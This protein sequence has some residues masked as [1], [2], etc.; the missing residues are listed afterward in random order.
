MSRERAERLGR[1]LDGVLT[2]NGPDDDP[3]EPADSWALALGAFAAS[4]RLEHAAAERLAR[5][6]VAALPADPDDDPLAAVLAYAMCG[7]AAAGT[8]SVGGWTDI[9]PGDTPTGDPLADAAALLPRLDRGCDADLFARYAVAEAALAAARVALADR[10]LGGP[11]A[12]RRELVDHPFGHV[13]TVLASRIASFSGRID[14]ARAILGPAPASPG[15]SRLDLLIAATRSLVEGNAADP[16][17]VRTI[18]SAV[19]RSDQARGDRIDVGIALLCAY[20]L[21]AQGAVRRAA[22]LATR[23]GWERAMVIDRVIVCELLTNAATSDGDRAA[24]EHWLARAE[25][26][27]GDP[28][29]DSTLD[30]VRSRMLLLAG[31]P[32]AAI[33]AAERSILRANEEGRA[34]EAAEGEI[35]AARARI[36][37]GRRGEAARRLEAA[38]AATR[39]TGYSAVK[40]SASRELHGTGR[41][42]RPAA[43]SGSSELSPRELEVLALLLQ[44]LGNAAIAA[45]LHISMHTARIHVSRILTAYGVPTRLALATRLLADAGGDAGPNAIGELTPRQRMVVAE[46]ATGAGNAEIARR[47]GI[48]VR[49]VEKHLTEAMRRSGTTSRV[50]LVIHAAERAR[51]ADA[52]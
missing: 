49:T 14:E 20:G 35:L 39:P 15:R 12:F 6:A 27:A 44:G 24:A 28:I 2:G 37:A 4:W 9:A 7:L 29:A 36:A 11:I 38:V 16:A 19:E 45:Q 13:M 41:R 43:G 8:G 23:P 26:F 42:L 32:D 51:P 17:V 25:A 1:A 40:R 21:I 52:E 48:A 34:I 47:L 18:A 3:A 30:R 5:A 31:E 46:A 33:D 22:R 10:V 50:G